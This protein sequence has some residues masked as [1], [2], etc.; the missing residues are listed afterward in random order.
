MSFVFLC[1][2]A[3]SEEAFHIQLPQVRARA[4][5]QPSRFLDTSHKASADQKMERVSMLELRNGKL[6]IKQ[7]I[8]S[9][10]KM[11]ET[12]QGTSAFNGFQRDAMW[13]DF[14]LESCTQR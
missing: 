2:C 7:K 13:R 10:E 1:S 12:M 9:F 11:S 3:Y 4:E 5:L 6:V 14:Q 8:L